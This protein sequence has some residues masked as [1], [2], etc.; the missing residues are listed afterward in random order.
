MKM[1]CNGCGM[2]LETSEALYLE[3]RKTKQML[4][5]HN[6]DCLRRLLR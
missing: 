4:Y 5:F 3:D 6:R 1:K 2:M